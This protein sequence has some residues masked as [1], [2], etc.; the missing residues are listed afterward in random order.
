MSAS[1]PVLVGPRRFQWNAGG[2]FGPSIGSSAWMVV[3]AYFLASQQQPALALLPASGFVILQI[4]AVM[5]WLLRGRIYP[6]TALMTLLGIFAIVLPAVWISVSL[7]ASPAALAA[8][9]WPRSFWVTALV[10]GMVP[11]LML[12]FLVLELSTPPAAR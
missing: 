6:F 9:N 11:F 1:S 2:W 12:W 4:A 7:T 10:C 5:L 8:M 3:T